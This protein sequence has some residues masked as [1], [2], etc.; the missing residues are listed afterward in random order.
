MDTRTFR[1]AGES[2]SLL[3]F[4]GM[5]FPVT[6]GRQDEIDETR[7]QDLVDAALEGGVNYFDT[8]WPY[9]GGQS[10]AALG[11]AL[12]RHPR[13]RFLYATKLPI[14]DVN[15]PADVGRLAAEQLR[16]CGLDRVDYY[17]VHCL[18]EEHYRRCGE[19][20]V[21]GELAALKRR[22]IIRRIGFSFHGAPALLARIVADHPWEFA[23]IQLNCVDWSLQDAEGQY[24]ILEAAGLP[25][26][27]MEPLRGGNLARL[28]REAEAVFRRARPRDSQ[29]AWSF[30]FAASLPGVLTVLSGM[31]T[32]EHLR[33]NLATFSPLEPLTAEDRIVLADAVAAYRQACR[34]PCTVCRYC[35]PCPAGVDIPRV[36][37]VYHNYQLHRARAHLAQEHRAL[38]PDRQADRCRRCGQCA[39]KCP[40]RIDIPA[41]LA[42]VLEALGEEAG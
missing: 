5:R 9:H 10:E 30:R 4:G 19:H 32:P 27:V 14:W 24:R 18:N 1:G 38:G 26:I 13:E 28:P 29:A 3:G 17:L 6:G 22:G 11:R 34:I 40:Q 23:Q 31:E 42:E 36:F 8:A 25:V 16:R 2:V 15:G 7:L 20:G 33:E 21:F 12:R 35:M 39:P 37:M 41:G